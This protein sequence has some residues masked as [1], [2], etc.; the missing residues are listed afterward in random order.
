MSDWSFSDLK[1]WDEKICTIA[2]SYGLD[3]HP[4]NYE[5]CDYYE[6]IG[7]MSYFGMPSHYQH[8]SY[9]KSFERTHQMYNA[10]IEGLP[11]ELIINS[12]PAIAY[13]MRQN[14]LYLQIMIMAHCVGHSDFFKNNRMF[15]NT[16]PDS[17]VSK[18]RNSRQRIQSYT[19]NP[20]IGLERVE[21]FIDILHTIKFQTERN[22]KKRKTR[23]EIKSDLIEKI[24]NDSS[25]KYD[26]ID[27]N[28]HI[29][30]PD[31]DLLGFLLDY[32]KHLE[33]WQ[34]DLIEVIR[35]ESQYL[36]PQIRTKILNEGWASFIHYKIFHELD[37]PQGLHIPC[38]KSHNQVIRPHVGNIN[39]YHLGFYLF[40]K[41][42]EEKG[43][44]ECLFIREIHDDEAALRMYLDDKDCLELNLFSYS[45]KKKSHTIDEISDDDGWKKVKNDLIKGTGL[46]SIP[47][48]CVA[49]ISK[50]GNL[51]LQHD[52]DGRDLQLEYAEQ[53]VEGMSELWPHQVKFFTIIEDEPWEI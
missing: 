23:K 13:L 53:V 27:I 50:S 10:G 28:A 45:E 40:K 30:E 44:E 11:Y 16:M 3:W 22:E 14:H 18:F 51:I 9:G 29:L 47:V 4:V 20:N 46:N 17:I 41:I 35:D 32:A 21:K 24:N 34:L 19:E 48:V 2:D 15:R 52:H 43:F 38:L 49:D 39:P 37:L 7:H 31:Y 5:V 1:I 12:N 6:M 33:D 25:G 8:W 36:I 26:N 42:E